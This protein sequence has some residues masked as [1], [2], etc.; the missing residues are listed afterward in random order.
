ML[1]KRFDVGNNFVE[2]STG[3]LCESRTCV[4]ASRLNLSVMSCVIV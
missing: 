4:L 3:V 1:Y 2:F